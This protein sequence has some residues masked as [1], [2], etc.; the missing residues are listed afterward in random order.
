MNEDIIIIANKIKENGGNLYLV[1]GAIRDSLLGKEIIDEDY[2]VTGIDE[3]TFEKLFPEAISRGKSFKVYDL[4]G[5]EFAMARKDK[6]SG[7][8]HKGFEIITGKNITIEEDL[9][10]KRYNYKFNSSRCFNR[11]VYRSI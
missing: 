7:I 3:N 5:K 4:Y 11:R 10:K 1:G 9:R 6:K 8:G 2:C